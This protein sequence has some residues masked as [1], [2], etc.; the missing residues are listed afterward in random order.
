[1]VCLYHCVVKLV[2]ANY[3]EGAE[4]CR[5]L[6]GCTCVLSSSSSSIDISHAFDYP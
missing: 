6:S 3:Q 4:Q 5:S 2:L 1:M